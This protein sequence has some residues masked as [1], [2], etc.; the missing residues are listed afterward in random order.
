MELEFESGPTGSINCSLNH[1]ISSHDKKKKKRTKC[2]FYLVTISV[3]FVFWP[4]ALIY[5]KE[6]TLP[7]D[8]EQRVAWRQ[9]KEAHEHLLVH[10][11]LGQVQPHAWTRECSRFSVDVTCIFREGTTKAQRGSVLFPL[12]KSVSEE[13][14]ISAW[15]QSRLAQKRPGSWIVPKGNAHPSLFPKVSKTWFQLQTPSS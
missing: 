11:V 6:N 3:L 9:K 8:E 2:S 14:G 13:D 12:Y 15:E 5:F 1:Y 7:Q 4:D 10:C